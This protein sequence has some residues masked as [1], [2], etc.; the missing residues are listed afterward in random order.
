MHEKWQKQILL[1]AHIM[2]NPQSQDLE[3]IRAVMDR[4]TYHLRTHSARSERGRGA[5]APKRCKRHECRA[6]LALRY[7]ED[8]F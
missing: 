7:R 2:N 5:G 3:T 6:S 4:Q 1:M 8:P